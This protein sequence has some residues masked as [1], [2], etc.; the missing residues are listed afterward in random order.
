MGHLRLETEM[1]NLR[2]QPSGPVRIAVT[3]TVLANTCLRSL[4]PGHGLHVVGPFLASH[5]SRRPPSLGKGRHRRFGGRRIGFVAVF[6][7]G[8][9]HV[10]RRTQFA[11]VKSRDSMER[12][13]GQLAAEVISEC[14]DGA[15]EWVT[16]DHVKRMLQATNGD[17]ALALTKI[18][19]AVAW[20]RDT[21]DL[22]Y[23]SEADMLKEAETRLIA[24]GKNNRPLVYTG[25]VNQ[26][27]GEVGSKLLACVW[28][29][30]LTEAGPTAQMD[31]VLDAHGYK[32]LLN[33]DVA[34]YVSLARYMNSYFAERFHRFIVIDAPQALV[35]TL[36]S[37][38]PLLSNR[39]RSRFV[40]IQRSN[41][42]Q[43]EALFEICVD[44]S[45]RQM[46]SQL[47]DMNKRATSSSNRDATHRLTASFLDHQRSQ[48]LS[49]Q[50]AMPP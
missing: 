4:L 49:N 28:D 5:P 19:E 45:M 50:Q 32:P 30:V 33:L 14:P 47:L 13:E 38:M 10:C 46:L 39:T 8:I 36:Q 12:R 31:Y 22:W 1:F 42:E 9:L 23:A 26:R 41:P 34:S 25:S 35:W 37:V 3:C 48:S 27:K 20:K 17:E 44:E 15:A 40:F 7:S 18:K 43:M 29:Q 11:H 21:L 2:P 16:G 24:I 6:A